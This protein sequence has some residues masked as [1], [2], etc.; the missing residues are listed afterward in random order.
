M[1]VPVYQGDNVSREYGQLSFFT[2]A[3]SP[4]FRPDIDWASSA[5]FPMQFSPF[6]SFPSTKWFITLNQTSSLRCEPFHL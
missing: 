6:I 1:Q 4:T 5:Q 3:S 2:G